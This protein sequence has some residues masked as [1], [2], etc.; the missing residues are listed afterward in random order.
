MGVFQRE[1]GRAVEGEDGEGRRQ[2][3][4]RIHGV[5][6]GVRRGRRPVSTAARERAG[7]PPG[8]GRVAAVR[9][10][11]KALPLGPRSEVAG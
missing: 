4:A 5:G 3:A 1:G 6:V 7:G 8:E 2:L 11:A 10:Q 9:D